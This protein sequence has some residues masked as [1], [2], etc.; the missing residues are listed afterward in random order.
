MKT[1][2]ALTT[3]LFGGLCGMFFLAAYGLME[4][5]DELKEQLE[6]KEAKEVEEA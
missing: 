4:E 1:F 2:L 6:Q 5:R 3:G